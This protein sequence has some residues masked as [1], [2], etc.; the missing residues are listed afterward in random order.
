MPASRGGLDGR[1][2][3]GQ[4]RYLNAWE[5]ACARDPPDRDSEGTSLERRHYGRTDT[6]SGVCRRNRQASSCCYTRSALVLGD[7]MSLPMVYPAPL[8]RRRRSPVSTLATARVSR[9][10]VGRSTN[11]PRLGDPYMRRFGPDELAGCAPTVAGPG[12]LLPAAGLSHTHAP[13]AWE[14][15]SGARRAAPLTGLTLIGR[16]C[17][18][19][20]G[21]YIKP[22]G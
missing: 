8:C 6:V 10:G 22:L 18:K 9:T 16:R 13:A 21:G 1:L 4:E 3:T 19:S 11:G 7:R 20:C 2:R 17:E 15:S 12:T 14:R 5:R